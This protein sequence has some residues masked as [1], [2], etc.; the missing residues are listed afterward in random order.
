[1]AGAETPGAARDGRDSPGPMRSVAWP[2]TTVTVDGFLVETDVVEVALSF[3]PLAV[4]NGVEALAKNNLDDPYWTYWRS[5][6]ILFGST[7]AV[8]GGDIA[9]DLG[10]GYLSSGFLRFL[11]VSD[12][13]KFLGDAIPAL[14]FA[15]GANEFNE[16]VLSGGISLESCMRNIYAWP[17]ERMRNGARLWLHSDAKNL[18]YFFVYGFFDKVVNCESQ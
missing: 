4:T 7:N 14:S 15:A 6:D 3:D 11:E 5:W 17:T 16:G 9:A 12:W 8:V 10:E 2:D 13:S 1:M 18:A